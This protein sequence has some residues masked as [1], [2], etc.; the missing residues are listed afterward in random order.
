MTVSQVRSYASVVQSNHVEKDG[1]IKVQHRKTRNYR[2]QGKKGQA[3]TES[4]DNF[5]AAER[6]IPIFITNVH[7]NTSEMDIVNYI[8][9]KTQERVFLE[10]IS[11]RRQCEYNAY[12]FL[13]FINKLPLYLDE[14]IWPQG[15]V[16]RKFVNFRPKLQSNGADKS[17]ETTLNKNG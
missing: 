15:I 2:L 11:I 5:K 17:N 16:F 7:K 6:K 8:E 13:V 12:K 1:W 14:K 3:V 4:D 10:K 9:K